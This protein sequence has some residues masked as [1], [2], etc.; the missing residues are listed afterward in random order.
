[1]NRI[2][3]PLFFIGPHGEEISGKKGSKTHLFLRQIVRC[4]NK[5]NSFKNLTGQSSH[6]PCTFN[7]VHAF[8]ICPVQK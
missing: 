4:K 1:M 2:Y 8:C 5:S 7:Y 3:T 6:V